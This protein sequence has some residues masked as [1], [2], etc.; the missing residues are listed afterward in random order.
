MRCDHNVCWKAYL[1][2]ILIHLGAYQSHLD[3][4][5]TITDRFK[6]KNYSVQPAE[7]VKDIFN[8]ANRSQ[9]IAPSLVLN[10]YKMDGT[11]SPSM[12][13]LSPPGRPKDLENIGEY[14]KAS[15]NPKDPLLNFLKFN[16]ASP[17]AA[18][19]MGEFNNLSA[20][21]FMDVDPKIVNKFKG[22]IFISMATFHNT[23]ALRHEKLRNT[24]FTGEN[25][26]AWHYQDN[27]VFE[28]QQIVKSG[29]AQS[30]VESLDD[31]DLVD[32]GISFKIRFLTETKIK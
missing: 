17:K 19:T 5:K 8:L 3:P 20:P 28:V 15:K 10:K 32:E 14:C 22:I 29:A 21:M 9:P 12:D 7:Y 13:G 24:K 1:P 26:P 31:L 18:P 16:V 25:D 4:K 23:G 11:K 2:E 30:A 27:T 6:D